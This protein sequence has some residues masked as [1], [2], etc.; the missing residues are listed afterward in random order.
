[1]EV[2]TRAEREAKGRTAIEKIAKA[3]KEAKSR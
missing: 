3:E 2:M 1:M